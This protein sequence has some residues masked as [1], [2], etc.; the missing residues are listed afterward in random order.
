MRVLPIEGASRTPLRPKYSVVR[1][2][3]STNAFL[4]GESFSRLTEIANVLVS[5]VRE[6][7]R[8][9][10]EEPL[11]KHSVRSTFP[12][13][14]KPPSRETHLEGNN[15]E[16]DHGDPE[17]GSSVLPSEQARVEETETWNHDPDEGGGCDDPR[18][19]TQ[20]V[21]DDGSI[22]EGGLDVVPS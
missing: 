8:I 7:E 18:H 5:T 14:T 19:V 15:S 6:S 17:H 9:A 12:V 13:C 22:C 1:E 3:S 21:D 11:Q 16:N 20:V 10:P 4:H 2:L